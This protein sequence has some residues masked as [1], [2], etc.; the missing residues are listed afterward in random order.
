[1]YRA[2][3]FPFVCSQLC[4]FCYKVEELCKDECDLCLEGESKFLIP[5]FFI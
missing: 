3:L 5:Y 4:L 2:V 1:M